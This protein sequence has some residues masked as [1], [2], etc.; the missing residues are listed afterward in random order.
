MNR[1]T[2][3]MMLVG[4]A[5]AMATAVQAQDPTSMAPPA[6]ETVDYSVPELQQLLNLPTSARIKEYQEDISNPKS[7][8]SAEQRLKIFG[9]TPKFI[10]FPEGTDPM[11]IPWVRARIVAEEMFQDAGLAISAK[12]YEKAKSLLKEIQEKYP[13][14]EPGQKAA[15]ELERIAKA[16]EAPAKEDPT[17]RAPEIALPPPEEIDIPEWVRTN[18][19]GV[20]MM[21]TRPAVVVVGNDFLRQGE[22]VPRFAG[23]QL[24]TIEPANVTYEYQSKDF[25]LDVDGSF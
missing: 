22:S 2:N 5:M 9:P 11:I 20:I 16:Q 25:P 21:S 13:T 15:S 10:Y 23:V 4:A 7:L 14:T 8:F 19:T 17:T 18:T 3:R 24:K 12:D 6:A 1:F